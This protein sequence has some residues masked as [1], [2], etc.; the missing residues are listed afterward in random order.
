MTTCA[1]IA[2]YNEAPRIA[3]VVSGIRPH[4]DHVLVVD[5]GSTDGTGTVATKAGAELIRHTTN[6]GKGTAIRSGLSVLTK[7]P[8]SHVLFLDGDMQHA[9]ADAPRLIEAARRGDGDF[10]LGERPF[11]RGTTPRARYYTNT[12]SSWVISTCFIGQRVADAQSGFRLI[13]TDLLRR[14]RLSGRGYEIETEMLI[15]LARRGARIARVP[16]GLHYHDSSSKLRPLRDTTKTCF[17]AVRYRFFPE[18]F[19]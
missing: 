15:K 12:I 14:V 3:E 17:L 7:R 13:D 10:I 6:R 16:I 1:L 9:P 5:D 8:F 11:D 4:V 2:A 19:Q 18:R